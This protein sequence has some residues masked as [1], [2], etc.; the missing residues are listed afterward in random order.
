MQIVTNQYQ[1]EIKKHGSDEF[2]LL[3]SREQLSRYPSGSFLWHWH[4][5]IE[6][7]LVTEGK[8]IY[9]VN[10]GIYLLKEGE[11]LF[12][13]SNA[14]HAGFMKDFQDCKYV[15]VTFDP[16][17]IYGFYQS[18]LYRKYVEPVIQDLSI[19]AIHMDHTSSWHRTFSEKIKKIIRLNE[20]KP[21][22]FEIDTI[23]ELLS[24][25]KEL[26]AN[27]EGE[28]AFQAHD[29]VEYERIREIMDYLEKNYSRK[30]LLKDVAAHIHLCESECSRL[31][32]RCMNT[33]LFTF[34][35][36]YR[37]E[38]SLEYLLN[39]EYSITEIAEK[40]GFTDSNYYSKVFSRLKGCSPI[41]YRKRNAEAAK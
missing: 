27:R 24:A 21:E 32:R 15:S 10:Q 36:E 11:L 28:P 4:P 31:F 5:E 20:E 9:K 25:W 17:L 1:K 16:K 26:L 18:V 29:R 6:I 2:P 12:E 3:V 38:R 7:T 35:Q 30:I 13:N 19:S 34:L 37:V 14:L 33:S 8:M 39:P 23:M 41:K 40:T 22:Y